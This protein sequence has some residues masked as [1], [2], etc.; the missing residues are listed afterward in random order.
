M[1]GTGVGVAVGTCDCARE[2]FG[3]G[4]ASLVDTRETAGTAVAVVEGVGV[5]V[6]NGVSVGDGVNV[7]DGVG[8]FVGLGLYVGVGVG[9][10]SDFGAAFRFESRFGR[11]TGAVVVTSRLLSA[12]VS[13]PIL[14]LVLVSVPDPMF[15]VVVLVSVPGPTFSVGVLVSVLPSPISIGYQKPI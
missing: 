10:F 14:V 8:V 9:L 4:V 13:E 7:G 5:F 3:V 12:F 11:C 15:S 2:L 1:G 6:G